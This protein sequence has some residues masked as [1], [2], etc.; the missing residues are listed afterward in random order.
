LEQENEEDFGKK[1]SPAKTS[2]DIKSSRLDADVREKK[3]ESRRKRGADTEGL[4]GGEKKKSGLED[5]LN[6]KVAEGRPKWGK[7]IS[8]MTWFQGRNRQNGTTCVSF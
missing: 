4:R 7:R 1:I 6:L 2:F 3:K 8:R 5:N